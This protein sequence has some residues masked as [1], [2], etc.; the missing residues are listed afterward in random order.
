MKNDT[1][2]GNQKPTDE[3]PP[4]DGE[5]EPIPDNQI[6]K[7]ENINDLWA[8]GINKSSQRRANSLLDKIQKHP[9]IITKSEHGEL[10][11]NTKVIPKSNFD[12]LFKAAFIPKSEV[13]LVGI[14]EF[15]KGLRLL[16]VNSNELSSSSFK[17]I[18]I[19][20]SPAHER[21]KRSAAKLEANDEQELKIFNLQYT[22]GKRGE[23]NQK[24]KGFQKKLSPS[25]PPGKRARVL[26]VY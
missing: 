16:H 23:T 11:L 24:G 3:L 26:Y 17:K 12:E 20:T 4:D 1:E 25:S 7:L 8:L 14:D 9:K 2:L 22:K 18:Y 5:M 6:Q 19:P 10:I 13:N 21:I 15:I